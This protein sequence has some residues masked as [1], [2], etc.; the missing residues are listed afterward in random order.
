M[1]WKKPSNDLFLS[2]TDQNVLL[3]KFTVRFQK[4]SWIDEEFRE[5]IHKR[6]ELKEAAIDTKGSEQRQMYCVMRNKV[7]KLNKR[8][9][10]AY[11]Q[12]KVQIGRMMV[13]NSGKPC[14]L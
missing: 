5:C 9:K 13:T 3:R 1:R 8:K 2:V 12:N 14:I 11:Y 7:M 4:A 6:D 10:K